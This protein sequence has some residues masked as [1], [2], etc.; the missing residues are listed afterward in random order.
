M[1]KICGIEK[2]TNAFDKHR[3]VCKVCQSAKNRAN[4]LNWQKTHL[5]RTREIK[6]LSQRKYRQTHKEEINARKSKARATSY[7]NSGSHT[8][9]E[10]AD[11]KS[12]YN[13]RCL[14]CGR[15]DIPM[16]KDHI[17][18]ITKGGTDNI[19]NIQPLCRSC[20]SS[21]NDTYIDYRR[22]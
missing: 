1:C 12:K 10:W 20:N 11:L 9:K 19:D 18:P 7:G 14:R 2:D 15:S 22:G 5:D 17:L 13:N 8:P 6:K 3:L 21:K 4:V 16:T